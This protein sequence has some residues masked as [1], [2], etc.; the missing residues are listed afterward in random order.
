MLFTEVYFDTGGD[1]KQYKV[2]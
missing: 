2:V 1:T